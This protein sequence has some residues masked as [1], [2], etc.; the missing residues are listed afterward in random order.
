MC[1]WPKLVRHDP[2]GFDEFP[3]KLVAWSKYFGEPSITS[4]ALGQ[5]LDQL[6]TT[7]KFFEIVNPQAAHLRYALCELADHKI[8]NE[9]PAI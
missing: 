2:S 4:S 3:R 8:A 1:R 5:F 9:S 7:N 6:M